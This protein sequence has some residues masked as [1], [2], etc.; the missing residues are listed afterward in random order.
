[1]SASSVFGNITKAVVDNSPE[2]LTALGVTGVVSTSYL[3]GKASYEARDIIIRAE[4]Y[5]PNGEVR[6]EPI[7]LSFREKFKKT[8]KLYIPAAA[9]GAVS[10]A[11]MVT[12]NRTSNKRTTAMAT[13]FSL[14]ERAFSEFREVT[15][16]IVGEA[17]AEHIR[18]RVAEKRM[19][20]NP[21]SSEIMI[22]P[23]G[24]VMCCD[25]YSRRYFHSTI[26]TLKSYENRINEILNNGSDYVALD[27]WYDM[28]GLDYTHES[29]RIGWKI[30]RGIMKIELSH[31]AVYD[32]SGTPCVGYFFNYLD[33]L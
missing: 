32:P 17:K 30:S 8:W 23:A 11:C 31:Q 3:A 15:S 20:E 5:H 24:K 27:D 7:M 14:S 29:G 25:L 13:A 18:D 21:P 22:A 16:E 1:M 19:S 28:V 4:F 10:I 6:E 9:S 33:E 12:S 26:E 2:I